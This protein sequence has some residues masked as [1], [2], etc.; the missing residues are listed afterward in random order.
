MTSC[1][2]RDKV[3]GK[4]KPPCDSILV[5]TTFFERLDKDEHEQTGPNGYYGTLFSGTKSLT[6]RNH[7]FGRLSA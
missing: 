2:A 3:E 6:A 4:S 1:S 5:F 7:S